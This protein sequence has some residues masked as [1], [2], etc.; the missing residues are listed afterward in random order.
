M[1]KRA[2]E[3]IEIDMSRI[4]KFVSD[5]FDAWEENGRPPTKVLFEI[6]SDI[7]SDYVSKIEFQGISGVQFF[8]L[9][10]LIGYFAKKNT[11]LSSMEVATY[12]GA[13]STA[14]CDACDAEAEIV[15]DS[16]EKKL[17]IKFKEDEKE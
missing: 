17:E 6:D 11:N 7:D 8:G 12:L 5:A 9:A 14:I 3:M 16:N 2:A 4:Q 1:M 10:H 13:L 15:K